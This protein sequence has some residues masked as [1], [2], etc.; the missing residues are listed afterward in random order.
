[1]KRVSS[2]TSYS[3]GLALLAASPALLP[4]QFNRVGAPTGV[5]VASDAAALTVS[6]NNMANAVS[7]TW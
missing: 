6:W 2:W 3:V 4:A 7:R 1:M 5:A